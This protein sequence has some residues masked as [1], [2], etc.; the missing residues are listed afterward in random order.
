MEMLQAQKD[1]AMRTLDE[2]LGPK[3]RKPAPR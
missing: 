2:M 1:A 3:R